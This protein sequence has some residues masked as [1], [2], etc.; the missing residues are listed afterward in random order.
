MTP[1]KVRDFHRALER[2]HVGSPYTRQEML[3]GMRS[4]VPYLL[5]WGASTADPFSV[6]SGLCYNVAKASDSEYD[7]HEALQATF[8]LW[9]EFSGEP[10]YPVPVHDVDGV[11]DPMDAYERTW[12]LW[13]RFTEYGRSRRRLS[14][15]VGKLWQAYLAEHDAGA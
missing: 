8:P 6:L 4:A 13:D 3:H 1:E 5:S 14:L 12:D 11:G 2:E 15:F 10:G 7:L 9:P